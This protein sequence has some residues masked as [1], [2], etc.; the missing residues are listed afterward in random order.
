MADDG[1]S[2]QSW[3]NKATNTSNRYED[4]ECINGFCDQI[5]KEPEGPQISVG[6]LGQ[7]I[8]S[9]QDWEVLQALTVLEAC[10]KNCGQRF[11]SEV[12]QFKFLN[13]LVKAISP[14]Y[15][16]DQ[17]SKRV[18]AKVIEMLY[19]W[20]VSLPGE[21]KI[22]EAY[23]MLKSQGIILSDPGTPC[24]TTLIPS[25]SSHPKNPVFDDE[26]RSKRL[27]DL[28]HNKKPRDLQEAN[29]FIKN[30]VREDE[31]RVQEKTRQKSTLE[32]VNISVNLLNEMLVHFSLETSSPAD[33]ELIRELYEDCQKLR[34][35]VS[36]LAANME[37]ND[38]ILGDILQA[39][40]DLSHVIS[41]YEKMKRRG[42]TEGETIETHFT[43]ATGSRNQSRS[44]IDLVDRDVPFS[45]E[46]LPQIAP[47][48][49]PDT[50]L[51]GFPTA[52]PAD[53]E[54]HSKKN[55]SN[56]AAL[57]LL[58]QDLLSLGLNDPVV[59][60]PQENKGSIF[61]PS[62]QNPKQ[63]L[64]L[65]ESSLPSVSTPLTYA[66]HPE[67]FQPL[68]TAAPS[69][70]FSEPVFATPPVYTESI[71]ASSVRLPQPLRSA[72]T[73]PAQ[74][75]L[76][77]SRGVRT[78]HS[79]STSVNNNSLQDHVLLDL[80]RPKNPAVFSATS[81][82]MLIGEQQDSIDSPPVKISQVDDCRQLHSHTGTL[83]Q[84]SQNKAQDVSLDNVH[85]SLDAI[86]PSKV[87]PVTVYDKNGV[88]VLLHFGR[89]CP[90][91]RPDV[92]VIVASTFN[93]APQSVRS[94]VLQAAVPKTMKVKLQQPSGTELAP[95]NPVLPPPAITQILLLANPLKE[96]VRMRYK[97]T[98][99]LGEQLF[100]EVGEVKAFPSPDR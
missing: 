68:P 55:I 44:L 27:A 58:D 25:P 57:S 59:S 40:D 92:L 79:L 39:S 75:P 45:S 70:I 77:Q 63:D 13:K 83:G 41:S 12:G 6:L 90:P 93:T 82:S 67:A 3:L 48:V 95:F 29:R 38:S 37:D 23:Q 73:T 61:L 20:T 22:C 72:L 64:H 94:I 50:M 54:S 91:G 66:K 74:T 65:F 4:W 7:K 1:Q 62:F 14:K 84:A 80:D 8:Q 86:Q 89:D 35:E 36:Q 87:C 33:Q 5:N 24:D 11:H 18:K 16:G 15:P 100:T 56:S 85:V 21:G 30:S 46:K 26:R 47:M 42:Q 52:A 9:P 98:F 69:S 76:P 43:S 53:V 78:P 34:Q 31:V 2:L 32:A 88:H 28:L 19:G 10:M 60:T 97:L 71:T 17:V 96:R 49:F 81:S 99:I 51:L